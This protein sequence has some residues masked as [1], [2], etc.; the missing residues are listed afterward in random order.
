MPVK[1]TCLCGKDFVPKRNSKTCSP[2]CSAKLTRR[3]ER[4]YNAAHPL[5]RRASSMKYRA[6]RDDYSPS[7]KSHFTRLVNRAVKALFQE[8]NYVT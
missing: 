1:L 4:A 6:V 7:S 3:R 5:Q 8:N 2:K